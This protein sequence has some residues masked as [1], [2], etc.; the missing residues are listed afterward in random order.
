MGQGYQT[1]GHTRVVERWI[2]NAPD[3]QTHSV[4][5]TR[6]NYTE[7]KTLEN[8]VKN[9]NGKY[10]F[11][12]NKLS[13]EEKAI[14]LRKLG[15]E[16]EY[17]VLHTHMEDSLPIIAFGVEEFKRPVLLYNHGSHMAWLGKSVADIVLDIEKDDEVTTSKRGITDTYFLGVPTKD[18]QFAKVDKI[19]L[20]KK[21][22]LPLDKKIIVTSGGEV[23]YRSISG[24]S[25]VDYLKDYVHTISH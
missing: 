12:E 5:F 24:H 3:V 1:G 8:N 25:F 20:R 17:V 2:E 11:L 9:K 23:R 18:K 7:L 19:E 22:N 10:I 6:E 14:E 4:V 21:L 16:Y 13:L 15:M